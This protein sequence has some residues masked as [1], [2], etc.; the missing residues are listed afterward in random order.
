MMNFDFQIK[1]INSAIVLYIYIVNIHF[2]VLIN[3]NDVINIVTLWK[4]IGKIIKN[5][6]NCYFFIPCFIT[7]LNCCSKKKYKSSIVLC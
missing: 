2:H 5:N 1:L 7:K 3:I 6:F 4:K